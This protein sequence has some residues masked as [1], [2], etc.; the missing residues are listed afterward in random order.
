MKG[1]HGRRMEGDSDQQNNTKTSAAQE[2]ASLKKEA[3]EEKGEKGRDTFP[4]GWKQCLGCSSSPAYRFH[5]IS[6]RTLHV[7]DIGG[8]KRVQALGDSADYAVCKSCAQEKLQEILSWKK[9]FTKS[10]PFALISLAGAGLA[11]ALRSGERVYV[12]FGLA[13][14]LAGI[15]GIAGTLGTARRQKAEFQGKNEEEA[16]RLAA[17]EVLKEKAPKKQGDEDLTYIPVDSYTLGRKNGDLMILYD[18]LPDIAI[19]A[20]GRIREEKDLR[21]REEKNIHPGKRKEKS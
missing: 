2:D 7:R 20:Y 6:V 10:L 8:E 18:L 12:I 15:L 14:V 16:L 9:A 11:F 1:K 4:L 21:P 13:A 19:Q 3:Q 17:W 5:V